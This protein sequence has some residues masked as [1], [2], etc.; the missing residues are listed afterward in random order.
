MR[1]LL[2]TVGFAV[3]VGLATAPVVAAPLDGSVPMLCA[4]TSIVECSQGGDC[5]RSSAEAAGVPAFIR[6]NV[7]RNELSTLDGKRTSPITKVERVDGRL[8][9][10]GLQNAR[11]WGAVID[12]TTGQMGATV[13]EADGAIVISGACIAP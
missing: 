9:I 11:V 5:Q 1:A 12:E 3:G 4:F 13:S 8:M 6:V 2:A 7:A 10:Q